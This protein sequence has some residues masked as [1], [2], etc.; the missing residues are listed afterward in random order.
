MIRIAV[1]LPKWNSSAKA[2]NI[3]YDWIQS[4]IPPSLSVSL[5]LISSSCI[6]P[7]AGSAN[8]SVGIGRGQLACFPKSSLDCDSHTHI[9]RHSHRLIIRVCLLS[10]QNEWTHP[11]IHLGQ[12][13]R[14][15]TGPAGSR[16]RASRALCVQRAV[17]INH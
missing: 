1:D 2:G 16:V 4:K 7:V 17:V 12:N 10:Y 5:G 14:N 6:S 9:Y 15:D 13:K 8:Q 11:H 3:N